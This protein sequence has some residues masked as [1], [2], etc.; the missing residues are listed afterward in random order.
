MFL[1]RDVVLPPGAIEALAAALEADAEQ[2][3]I[4][5]DYGPPQPSPA[6]HVGMG[7]VMFPRPVLE[8]ITFRANPHRCECQCCCDDLRQMGF[9]VDYLPGFRAAHV[10]PPLTF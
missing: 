4:G 9:K 6:V 10:K 2:G 5:I 8:R 3:A 7:A 1:D